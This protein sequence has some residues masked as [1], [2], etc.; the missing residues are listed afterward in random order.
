MEQ[1]AVNF[2][3]LTTANVL[4]LFVIGFIGGLV[5][6]FIAA[7]SPPRG[8]NGGLQDT[9]TTTGDVMYTLYG[10]NGSGSAAIEAALGS[11]VRPAASSRQRRGRPTTRSP[12]CSR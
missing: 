1:V 3:D 9:K 12:R 11:S 8:A 6:G 5:S 10:S 2:I 4:A 7:K